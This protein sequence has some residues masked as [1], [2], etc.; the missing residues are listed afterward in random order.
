M[1][2]KRIKFHIKRLRSAIRESY[3]VLSPFRET[4]YETLRQYV[5]QWYGSDRNIEPVPINLIAE[6]VDIY[7]RLMAAR[8]PQ[9]VVKTPETVDDR[10]RTEGYLL[11]LGIEAAMKEMKL[12]RELRMISKDALMGLGVAQVG[13]N[14]AVEQHLRGM[15]RMSGAPFVDWISLND[16]AQD[17]AAKRWNQ[18]T[19][20]GN[21]YRMPF[22]E[23]MDSKLFGR[24]TK[25]L[26]P[27]EGKDLG[28]DASTDPKTLSRGQGEL[29]GYREYIDLW[30]VYIPSLK[31]IVTL[32]DSGE[33]FDDEE[34]DSYEWTGDDDGPYRRLFFSDVPDQAMPL[35]PANI[36]LDLHHVANRLMNKLVDQAQRQKSVGLYTPGGGDDAKRLQDAEDGDFLRSDRPEAFKEATVGGIR[37]ELMAAY[38]QFKQEFS[39]QAGN[40]D[41]LGGLSPQSETA[42]QDQILNQ[43]AS[44][45][46]LEMMERYEEFVKE[47][48]TDIG[49]IIFTDPNRDIL[50]QLETGFDGRTIPFR[51]KADMRDG[52]FYMHNIDV[53]PFSTRDKPP[54]ETID[55]VTR[56]VR[57]AVALSQLDPNMTIDTQRYF[58][59]IA[60]YSNTPEVAELIKFKAPGRFDN[61][62]VGQRPTKSPVTTRTERRVNIPGAT[63]SGNDGIL[64]QAL[65]TQ[66]GVQPKELA[67]LGRSTG[68]P[69]Q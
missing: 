43:N 56:T 64:A 16:W 23:V 37:P 10:L 36:W 59:I 22:D 54:A 61:K 24:K 42:T 60:E 55:I 69:G 27:T 6:A 28:N 25:R 17:M 67:A 51:W 1:P 63:R 19:W 40:L 11:R 14:P 41:L 12:G 9:V 65:L 49:Y 45:R 30:D 2:R 35:P 53:V 52:K 3:K 47:V 46:A 33:G 44:R 48:V 38:L 8:L 5:G 31:T 32:P 62:P 21:R 26:K 39:A 66:G 68:A 57:E 7:T 34:L 20:M 13:A 58:E 18:L 29:E 4:R 15:N 50:L